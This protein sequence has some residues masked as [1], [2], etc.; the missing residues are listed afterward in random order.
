MSEARILRF[1]TRDCFTC[2]ANSSQL[3]NQKTQVNQSESFTNFAFKTTIACFRVNSKIGRF[4][5]LILFAELALP[6]WLRHI[7]YNGFPRE[8]FHP[9][10][11]GGS[12]RRPLPPDHLT[13]W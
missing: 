7:L 10:G 4:L 3:L 5:K 11:D 1:Q 2:A 12:G 13:F 8:D 6:S 9:K